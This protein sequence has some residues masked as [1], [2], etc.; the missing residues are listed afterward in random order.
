MTDTPDPAELA[1][2]FVNGNLSDVRKA[3]ESMPPL[4]AIRMALGVLDDLG[5]NYGLDFCLDF[6][7]CV[8][9]WAN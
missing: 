7:R 9:A 6:E 3:L 4:D 5:S 1:E 8:R 2:A